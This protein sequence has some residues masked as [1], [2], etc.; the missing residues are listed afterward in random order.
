MK[1]DARKRNEC[2]KDI[3]L[4]TEVVSASPSPS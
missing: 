4:K 3:E 1:S 2:N